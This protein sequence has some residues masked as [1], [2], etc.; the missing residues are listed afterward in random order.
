MPNAFEVVYA[1]VS[2]SQKDLWLP[3]FSRVN[4]RQASKE[5][6]RLGF[7]VSLAKIP[8]VA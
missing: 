8:V 4:L 1:I 6:G 5:L 2:Q 3:F 7:R